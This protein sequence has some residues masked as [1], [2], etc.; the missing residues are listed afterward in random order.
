MGKTGETEI[1]ELIQMVTIARALLLSWTTYFH[2][3]PLQTPCPTNGLVA[4]L[5]TS[6]LITNSSSR[7]TDSI[8]LRLAPRHLQHHHQ[9]TVSVSMSRL[10][11]QPMA[12]RTHGLS[13]P[14]PANKLM[15]T[16]RNTKSSA[17]SRREITS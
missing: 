1:Q 4:Q 14:A 10:P 13:A 7:R 12:M 2:H 17:A 16:T 11:Q 8:A 5:M 3:T 9:L 15:P 6:G